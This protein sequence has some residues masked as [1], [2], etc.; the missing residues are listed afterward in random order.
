MIGE[1]AFEI[2]KAAAP[3]GVGAV[4]APVAVGNVGIRGGTLW[5][6]IGGDANVV[7]SLAGC[8]ET[9]GSTGIHQGGPTR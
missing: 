2:A 5:I 8:W 7:A 3:R 4:D 1:A 9:M 6:M